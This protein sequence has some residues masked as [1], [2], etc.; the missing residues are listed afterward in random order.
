MIN[1]LLIATV[2]IVFL[3]VITMVKNLFK[4]RGSDGDSESY[5]KEE[6][7]NTAKKRLEGMSGSF[8]RLALSFD[9]LT[10]PKSTLDGEDMNLVFEGISSHLCGNCN[11]C[12]MC[13]EKHFNESYAATCD[14]LEHARE[15]GVVT[16]EDLPEQFI[17]HC[18]H[19]EE[20][21]Q[22]TNRNL[23]LAK[24]K[25]SWHNRLAESREAVA[26]QLEEVAKIVKDF[27]VNL[28]SA[29]EIVELQK[30]KINAKLRN[31]HVK[32]QRVMM[33]E[34]ENRGMELHLRARCK[35]GR[36]ITTKEAAMLIG[37]AL[38]KKFVPR[39]D[40]R[41]VIGKEYADYVFCED[42]NFKVLTGVARASKVRGELSGDNF[43]FLYPDSS[44]VVMMLS[45]GMGTGEEAYK[46]SEM[47]I[48]LLEEFLEAGFREE[49][50]VKLINSVL[51]L[52]SE[53]TM[54]STV[55][56]CVINL[57]AGTCE[58][59]KVGAATTFIKRQDWVETISS[60]TMPAG[61][62]NRVEFERKCKKL[63]DGDFVIMVSDGVLDCIEEEEKEAFLQRVIMEIT[64]QNPQEIANAILTAALKQHG[65]EPVDDMTVLVS[66][67][68]K[69]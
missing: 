52:K 49:P 14:L 29:G 66:G 43:S 50:A 22:E 12:R 53:H 17:R 4:S 47:V 40:S 7:Q 67:I 23:T 61:M 68:W 38:N 24:M 6:L 36:C 39:E 27:S 59:V 20:F 63:Y 41:N 54:F 35:D 13:W 9:Q 5:V 2:F 57:C 32:I 33:F 31:H 21:I 28:C 26:G 34:R 45:D 60:T 51:V 56:L 69:K 15:H 55:D 58:F 30:R 48:E 16:M 10:V 37:L 19:S 18:I 46:E 44:D 62:L 1:E 3:C 42:A 11:K 25:L 64:Q 65:Y 8:N